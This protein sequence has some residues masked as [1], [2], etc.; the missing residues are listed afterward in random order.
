MDDAGFINIFNLEKR[1]AEESKKKKKTTT[2]NPYTK[3][4]P[5]IEELDKF[6]IPDEI[7][8]QVKTVYARLPEDLKREY[9][10]KLLFIR[11]L[12]QASVDCKCVFDKLF[13]VN[14][15]NFKSKTVTDS[16][17]I[18]HTKFTDGEY[19]EIEDFFNNYI[20]VLDIEKYKKSIL[21]FYE[22][23]KT[24]EEFKKATKGKYPHT[25][26]SGVLYFIIT[27]LPKCPKIPLKE[28]CEK[29]Y[30]TEASVKEIVNILKKITS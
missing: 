11:C 23:I 1:V 25:T 27:N 13:L 14:N 9:Q 7:K 8:N 24:N 3:T 18:T 5:F 6:Y 26:S 4:Y 17:K 30:K 28:Y 19:L 2:I 22:K 29:I 20:R 12:F 16:F 21:K 10:T 15:F